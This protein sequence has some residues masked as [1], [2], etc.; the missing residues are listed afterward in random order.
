MRTKKN[1][2]K[3]CGRNSV[4]DVASWRHRRFFITVIRKESS[5]LCACPEPYQSIYSPTAVRNSYE[6]TK[7][8]AGQ[9]QITINVCHSK[10]LAAPGLGVK[11]VSQTKVLCL[12]YTKWRSAVKRNIIYFPIQKVQAEAFDKIFRFNFSIKQ[13]RTKIVRKIQLDF[14]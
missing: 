5:N 3:Q 1:C 7:Y 8:E 13:F 10:L 6:Q 12:I 2:T 4:E 9:N 14:K 11:R